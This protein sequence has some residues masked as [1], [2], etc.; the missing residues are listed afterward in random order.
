VV[1]RH[2]ASIARIG[3]TRHP[4]YRGRVSRCS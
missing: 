1:E 4:Q 2:S 3:L